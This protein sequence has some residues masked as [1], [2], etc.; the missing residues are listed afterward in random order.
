MDCNVPSARAQTDR[1]RQTDRDRQ[2]QFLDCNAVPS[3]SAQGYL[4]TRAEGGTGRE[5]ERQT[6]KET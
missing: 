4:R 6:D 2:R 1:E 5:M 3:G